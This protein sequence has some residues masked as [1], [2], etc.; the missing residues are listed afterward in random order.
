M[1]DKVSWKN[2]GAKMMILLLGKLLKVVLTG[3]RSDFYNIFGNAIHWNFSTV[4]PPICFELTF[5]S[6]LIP[7]A[8]K[9]FRYKERGKCF[10]NHGET[11]LKENADN[12]YG[13]HGNI[14]KA[15][16]RELNILN[17]NWLEG[18]VLKLSQYS[19]PFLRYSLMFGRD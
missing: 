12:F 2:P 14:Q 17:E 15:W 5:G 7:K 19:K 3:Y 8:K 16:V 6:I 13:C 18:N 11:C 1:A 10:R 4:K 9:H